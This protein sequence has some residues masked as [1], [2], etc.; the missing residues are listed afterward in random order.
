MAAQTGAEPGAIVHAYVEADEALGASRRR[1]ELMTSS[2]DA[3]GE[4][5]QL[6]TIEQELEQAVTSRLA[7]TVSRR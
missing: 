6:L 2:V 1:D 7:G 5:R 3:T 4:R